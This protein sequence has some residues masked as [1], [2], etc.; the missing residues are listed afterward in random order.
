[1]SQSMEEM[2]AIAKRIS[3]EM[4]EHDE[5]QRLSNA[6]E[7]GMVEQAAKTAFEMFTDGFS[8]DKIAKYTKMPIEWVE[9]TLS[10]KQ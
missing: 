1:M 8:F 9:K 2:K 7:K 10:S 6:L 4:A 5:A 3:R